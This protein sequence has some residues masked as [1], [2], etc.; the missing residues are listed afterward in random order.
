MH[1]CVGVW[2][3][4]VW[5]MGARVCGCMVHGCVVHGCKGV[6]VHGAWMYGAW[7]LGCVGRGHFR[8]LSESLTSSFH[9]LWKIKLGIMGRAEDM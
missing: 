5:C 4:G 2:C 7:V 3:M 9:Q 6:W 1:G 8:N